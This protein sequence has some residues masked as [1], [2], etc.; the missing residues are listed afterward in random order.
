MDMKRII[1]AIIIFLIGLI[2]ASIGTYFYLSITGNEK[3]IRKIDPVNLTGK[4]EAFITA[5]SGE[6]FIL[7]TDTI[8]SAEIGEPL[9]AGDIIKVVDDSFCQIQFANVAAAKI[10]SNS[11]IR[12]KKILNIDSSPDIKTE[13]L[14]GSM[15]YRVN[16]LSRGEKLEVRSDDRI[17]SVRG[18]TFF[19]DKDGNGTLLTVEE[20]LV[21][22]SKRDSTDDSLEAAAGNEVFLPV[23]SDSETISP[24]SERS[25]NILRDAKNL[26]LFDLKEEKDLLIKT[27]IITIPDDAQIYVN[28][29]LSGRGTFT[30]LFSKM[31]KLTFLIR[32]RGYSDK[33]LSV[34]AISDLEYTIYLDPEGTSEEILEEELKKNSADNMLSN[35]AAIIEKLGKDLISRNERISDIE[36]LIVEIKEQNSQLKEEQNLSDTNIRKLNSRIFALE[37][38][39]EDLSTEISAIRLQLEESK[40]KESKLR[41]LIKQIQDISSTD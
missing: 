19:I 22:I 2:T 6:V 20:G 28:G 15:L 7:R 18:T 36:G 29:L 32:K 35:S 12:I 33:V 31:D 38:Q 41:E 34:Q 40:A 16:E 10:R 13:V 25:N 1:R 11:I 23:D 39:K 27:S 9:Y 30:G 24:I 17:F 26:N 37:K 14:T 21:A 4:E 8:I 5:I 3:E